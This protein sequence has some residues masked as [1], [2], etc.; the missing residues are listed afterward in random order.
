MR[1]LLALTW[2]PG[3]V[4]EGHEFAV[5]SEKLGW[6]NAKSACTAADAKLA[7]ITSLAKDQF[8]WRFTSNQE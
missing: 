2:Q 3:D 7:V 5:S 8:L 6:N 4:F 1:F